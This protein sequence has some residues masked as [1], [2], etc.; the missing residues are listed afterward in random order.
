MFMPPFYRELTI[1]DAEE[2]TVWHRNR[3]V[4]ENGIV[5]MVVMKR[6][7]GKKNKFSKH[8]LTIQDFLSCHQKLTNRRWKK[9]L[10]SFIFIFKISNRL[11]TQKTWQKLL[12][13]V[14]YLWGVAVLGLDSDPDHIKG[15]RTTH[16]GLVNRPIP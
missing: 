11:S 10:F 14:M 3:F 4:T 16:L 5:L 7:V 8:S 13:C 12:Y 15:T 9:Y 2:E 6:I 1:S